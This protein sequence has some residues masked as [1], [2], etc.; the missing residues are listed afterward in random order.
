MNESI[1]DE[2]VCRTAPATP[3]LLNM[4]PGPRGQRYQEEGYSPIKE[5]WMTMWMG[6][7]FHLNME[8]NIR[9]GEEAVTFLILSHDQG[10]SRMGQPASPAAK[11]PKSGP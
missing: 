11:P 9:R 7:W 6:E 4:E 3:G 10:H 1:N 2:G 5:R 8:S